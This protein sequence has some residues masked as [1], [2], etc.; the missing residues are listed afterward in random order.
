MM[1][2]RK[3]M[4]G[5]AAAATLFVGMAFGAG[6][7]DAVDT[8]DELTDT[9]I[10]ITAS[11]ADQFKF[12]D[13][14]TRTFKYAK[15]ADYNFDGN[16]KPY[17]TTTT[18][19][20]QETI[21]T[22][23]TEA[24]LTP[25]ANMDPFTWLGSQDAATIEGTNWRQFVENTNLQGLANHD[26]TPT[27]S[28][29]GRTLTFD[30][31]KTNP[32]D[33]GL[34]LIIDQS[35]DYEA[36]ASEGCTI[37][38]HKMK[39]ILIGT[40]LTDAEKSLSTGSLTIADAVWGDIARDAAVA[41]KSTKDEVCKPHPGFTKVGDDGTTGL[42]GAV[43][44]VY[45]AKDSSSATNDSDFKNGALANPAN[46]DSTKFEAYNGFGAADSKTN[47][48]TSGTGGKVDFGV[49]PTGTYYVYEST[50]PTVTDNSGK[51]YLTSFRAVLKVT[52]T[53]GTQ[54]Q[55]GTYTI[56]DLNNHGLLTG[57]AT[58][59]YKYRNITSI[60]HLPLTGAAGTAMFAVVA[61]LL[62]AGAGV[63]FARSRS[64]KRALR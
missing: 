52:V 60:V 46:I 55:A 26:I 31:T 47:T 32:G 5:L 18:G 38:Y 63:T 27:S 20:D 58:N 62:A 53:E 48:L 29:E 56:E 6:T 13:N 16:N 59:G 44:S 10:R 2:F 50:M 21:R 61:M 23:L 43:F 33:R 45:T 3:V 39:A 19:V 35:G 22:A 40:K 64:V 37:T 57:D 7:A 9:Q 8:A 42:Q 34:Y 24:G 41:V 4:A 36:G 51:Q 49:L 25:D 17:L 54:G 30:F 15:L 1:K 14:G 28:D 11:S 12:G